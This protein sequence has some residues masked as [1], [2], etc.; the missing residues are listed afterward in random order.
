M[1]SLDQPNVNY[2]R[3]KQLDKSGNYVNSIGLLAILRK[4]YMLAHI[5]ARIKRGFVSVVFMN[6]LTGSLA[7]N[8]AIYTIS[9]PG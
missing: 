1:E 4:S 7:V 6:F 5:L 8:G 9:E 2:M 3:I